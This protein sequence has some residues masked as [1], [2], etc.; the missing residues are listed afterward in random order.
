MVYGVGEVFLRKHEGCPDN[1]E[2]SQVVVTNCFQL[3]FMRFV[4]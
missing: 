3:Y 1:S 2:I 4:L